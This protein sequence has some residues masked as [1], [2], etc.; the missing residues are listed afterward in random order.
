M[1]LTAIKKM[2]K[3]R[4]VRE[5]V[6]VFLLLCVSVFIVYWMRV[7]YYFDFTSAP[8]MVAFAFPIIL[9]SYYMVMACIKGARKNFALW[10]AILVAFCGI[11]YS[12]A[13]APLQVPDETAHF[14]RSY[15]MAGGDID[16]D[17]ARVYP[18][19][20]GLLLEEFEPFY[21]HFHQDEKDQIIYRYKSYFDRLENGD[22]ATAEEPV[23]MLILPFIP[24]ALAMA[25]L[26]AL[27]V[28]ALVCLFAAR[29]ANVLVFA[30]ICYAALCI[31]K[32][33]RLLFLSFMLLPTT[34]FMAASCSY[35]SVM[36]AVS[37]LLF[38]YLFKDR[39]ETK[40]IIIILLLTFFISHI[41]IPNIL[42]VV[43]MFAIGKS[44]W[45]TRIT[46]FFFLLLTVATAIISSLFVSTYASIFSLF[47]PIP[48]LDS[49]NPIE[50][51]LFILSNIP[52]YIIVVFGSF[53]ENGFYITQLGT[54]GWMDTVVPLVSYIS[55]PLLFFI[56]IFYGQKINGDKQ[57]FISL[58]LFTVGYA[59]VAISGIYITNTPV[60]MV[61]VVGVQPRYFLPSLYSLCLCIGMFSGRFIDIKSRLTD[62]VA[63]VTAGGFSVISAILLFLTHNVIW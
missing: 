13:N 34:M 23:M 29:I 7:F 1:M 41:K 59:L 48:R 42:L 2:F 9:L 46:K 33:F 47:E 11:L 20:V 6:T 27:G 14:L 37:I 51:V 58:V 4:A 49:V 12:F 17:P 26:R 44:Q 39:I 15:A 30:A 45:I 53:Y 19:D 35:D 50:Q 8:V 28:N 62:D 55:L 24:S 16:F 54:F 56:A 43:P 60:A 32:R 57:L 3:R 36:L 18:D 38:A 63:V 61:R 40:D 21:S 22:T 10:G 5:A 31:A 25:P 52:R